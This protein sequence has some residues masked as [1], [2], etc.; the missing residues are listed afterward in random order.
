MAERLLTPSK[1]TA[2]LDCA[3]YLTL[4]NAVDDG[5]LT[6]PSV[7]F[8]SMAQLLVDKGTAHEEACL[9][10]Y[11]DQGLSVL[12]VPQRAERES[13]ENWMAR[14]P[15]PFADEHDVIYQQP[16]I[17]EGVRG[18]AD[19]LVKST[20]SSGAVSYEPVDAKLSRSEAKPGHVLQLCFYADAIEA[21]TGVL[22]EYLHIW[23]GSGQIESI[24]TVDVRSYWQRLK[25]QLASL[26]ADSTK[27]DDTEPEPCAHCD[28]CEFSDNCENQW[29]D[30]DALHYVAGIRTTD[31][32]HLGAVGVDALA[33]LGALS[34]AVVD[35]LTDDRLS[36]LRRQSA[37]Q[38]EARE[39]PES[40]P[41]FS[42]IE[43]GDDPMWGH[44]FS[45]IPEPD[46][47]D[48]FLDFEGHPFWTAKT[49]L[50]FLFGLIT[51]QPD[52]TWAYDARWA[53]DEDEEA[54]VT[55]ALIEY[56]AARRAAHPGMHVYHYNHTERSSLERLAAKY[57]VAELT[58]EDLINTGCFVDLLTVAR[59]AMQVGVESYGLKYLEILT[60]YERRHDIDA[61]SGAVVAYEA[62]MGNGDSKHLDE[63]AAYNDDDVRATLALRD[64]L[65]EQ[66]PGGLPWRDPRIEFEPSAPE[67]DEQIVALHEFPPDSLEH[68]LGDLLGYW[69]REYRAYF[70][71]KFAK[72][73]LDFD[74]LADDDEAIAGLE[75]T[76][77][78]ERLGARGQTITPGMEFTFPT[79]ALP[80]DL[81]KVIYRAGDQATYTGVADVGDRTIQLVWNDSAREAGTL[82]TTVVLDD[83]IGPKPK[84]AAV[85][86]IATE[87]LSAGGTEGIDTPSLELLRAADPR[88]CTEGIPGVDGF[89]DDVATI[90]ALPGQ[91][92]GSCL[93]V[94]GP[95]GT[96]KTYTGAHMIYDLLRTG[97]RVGVTAMSHSAIN[98][99]LEALVPVLEEHGAFG[100]LRGARQGKQ[101]SSGGLPGITYGATAA[102]C[103]K[104][105]YNLVA[106]TTWH[107]ANE[108][109]R[110][111][112]VDVLIV[113]EAGQLAL[114][115]ALAASASASARS[116]VLLG[117]PL[118][119]PQVSQASHPRGSGA[120]VLEHLLDGAPTVDPSRGVFL[121]VTRRMHPDVCEFISTQIYE[122]RLTSHES[123]SQQTT[124]AGT[125]LRWL[126]AHHAERSTEA[127][128][129]AEIVRGEIKK[130]IGSPWTNQH[131][132]TAP[133]GADDFMVVAPYNDQVNLLRTYLDDDPAT[134]GV[135]VGTVDKFQGREAAVVFF[136]MT[137]SDAANMPRGAD[138]LF[139]RN[140]LNVAISRARCLAY[141]VC[142]DELLDARARSVDDMRLISTLC[143]FVE[144]AKGVIR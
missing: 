140:R 39:H 31:I 142:T 81:E 134:N 47:G 99:L 104:D 35:G 137:T 108:K 64:W 125:G 66:R 117:D 113:D 22:P 82:P 135:P 65:L 94:Q 29:R 91:L 5:E 34:D 63:I 72:T 57:G 45:Q 101:P 56:F 16:F 68:L 9:Q 2:W 110:D 17:H 14:L 46:D 4:R 67:I 60:G 121:S 129:E 37:L 87:V 127:L 105:E 36:R 69:R 38:V 75:P 53:H 133:L 111:A 90:A 102:K 62:Y 40:L 116:V 106:G 28:F 30:A 20:T 96:G 71:P 132:Q 123:C 92:D 138:F 136:T 24:R 97:K 59:N 41:P 74:A 107:F 26:L 120:S 1:I 78:V 50:F 58:L 109:L 44:G 115:D 118:Q 3:H 70:A 83:H 144:H 19:F 143:A 114:V 73:S 42:L 128:E 13:F 139:S 27:I 84:P 25:R 23:L 48:V 100:L 18:I 43:A 93:A 86:T 79:Q 130:L 8:G 122:G 131:G 76:G 54:Q 32:E 141:L 7:P 33:G 21:T 112:P 88:F 124:A 61:G 55:E 12:E 77:E 11:R 98:N 49:G 89:G 15:D 119:L 85:S 10:H 103:A 6:E 95:P 80:R 52:G 51:K 126:C